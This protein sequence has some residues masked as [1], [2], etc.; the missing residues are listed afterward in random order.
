MGPRYAPAG[1]TLHRL[2]E[3]DEQRAGLKQLGRHRGARLRRSAPQARPAMDPRTAPLPRTGTAAARRRR[4]GCVSRPP[5]RRER[6]WE[7]RKRGG[8]CGGTTCWRAFWPGR[9]RRRCRNCL[10]DD[11]ARDSR[12]AAPPPGTLRAPV[13][14]TASRVAGAVTLPQACRR[15]APAACA[16][17]ACALRHQGLTPERP[18]VVLKVAMMCGGCKGAV[19]RVLEKMEGKAS[20]QRSRGGSARGCSSL[21]PRGL[22][23]A[24]ARVWLACARKTVVR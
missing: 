12:C 19:T 9:R 1:R 14:P 24:D 15:R 8:E 2:A 4:S 5:W 17:P 6:P 18:Q 7:G 11:V 3:G 13:A 21:A 20:Q 22:A 10:L 23:A 16:R